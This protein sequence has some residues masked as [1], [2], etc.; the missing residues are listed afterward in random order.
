MPDKSWKAFERRI[1]AAVGGERRGAETSGERGGKSDVIHPTIAPECKLLGRPS[2][3]AILDACKQAEKNADGKMPLAFV[4]RK[5]LADSET[6]VAIRLE[7]WLRWFR[8]GAD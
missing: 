3:G 8:V 6:I 7:E 1:A 2:Y 4:K 5:N